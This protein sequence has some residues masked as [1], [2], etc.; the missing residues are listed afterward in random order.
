MPVLTLHDRRS[1]VSAALGPADV[2]EVVLRIEVDEFPLDGFLGPVRR[3]GLRLQGLFG[4][5]AI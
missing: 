3:I 4:F 2:V 5:M 1:R